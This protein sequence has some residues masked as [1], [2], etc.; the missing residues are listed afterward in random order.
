MSMPS[1]RLCA[2]RTEFENFRYKGKG[3]VELFN[4]VDLRARAPL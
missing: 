2:Q 1:F 4:D 3:E